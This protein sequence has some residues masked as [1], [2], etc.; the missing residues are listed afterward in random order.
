MESDSKRPA[1]AGQVGRVASAIPEI[2]IENR[3]WTRA[4]PGVARLARRAADAGG[5]CSAIVLSSDRDVRR[6][7]ARHRG[8]DKPTNV[9]TFDDGGGQGGGQLILAYGTVRREAAGEGRRFSH[10]LAHLIVHG[11][12]HLAGHDH[13]HPGDARRMEMAETRALSRLKM[14]DPWRSK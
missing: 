3:A 6:L 4:L 7:N 12:L 11:A 5:G 8:R 10:H 9:L 2:L 1:L 14:P 13:H